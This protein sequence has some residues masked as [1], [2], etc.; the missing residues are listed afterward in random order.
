LRFEIESRV[1]KMW[2]DACVLQGLRAPSDEHG[3]RVDGGKAAGRYVAGWDL[4][5]ELTRGDSKNGDGW[6]AHTPLQLLQRA[7][8]GDREAARAWQQYDR[9]IVGCRQLEW[10]RGLRDKYPNDAPDVE[11][12]LVALLSSDQARHVARNALHAKVL[13]AVETEGPDGI[14]AVLA[15]ARATPPEK[16]RALA[17]LAEGARAP[18]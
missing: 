12:E 7:A 1:R 18:P 10:S 4:A 2:R 13:D 17:P 16:R 8:E 14:Q 11:T 5:A 9:A 15:E 3:V 6:E